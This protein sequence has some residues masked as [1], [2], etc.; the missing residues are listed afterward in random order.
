MHQNNK[1]RNPH[2]THDVPTRRA[3]IVLTF[4]VPK[5]EA[6]QQWLDA[7]VGIIRREVAADLGKSAQVKGKWL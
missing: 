7:V 1:I 4:E 3:E 6:T 2:E 5:A